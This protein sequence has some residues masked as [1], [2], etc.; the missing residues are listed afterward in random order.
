MHNLLNVGQ[1]VT[2]QRARPGLTS[3]NR[4]PGKGKQKYINL[5]SK[6]ADLPPGIKVVTT[7]AGRLETHS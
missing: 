5:K 6:M 2:L 1:L 4:K 7:P 3:M